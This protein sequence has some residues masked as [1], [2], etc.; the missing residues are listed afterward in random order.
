MPGDHTPPL[1]EGSTLRSLYFWCLFALTEQSVAG[2]PF[3]FNPPAFLTGPTV[4]RSATGNTYYFSGTE[5]HPLARLQITQ[6][7]IP[8]SLVEDDTSLCATAFI[9]EIRK[10]APDIFWQK[11]STHLE[12]GE[13]ALDLWRWNGS[14]SSNLMTG[15]VSCGIIGER[16]LAITFQDAIRQAPDSFPVLRELLKKLDIP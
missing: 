1:A 13:H 6:V 8:D 7:E 9:F 4:S 14:I 12:A 3:G 16:F 15:I 11:N 5:K 10:Q 2:E